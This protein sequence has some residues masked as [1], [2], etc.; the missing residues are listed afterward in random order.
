M[1]NVEQTAQRQK[2]LFESP[3][4]NHNATAVLFIFVNI[5]T[6]IGD[7]VDVSPLIKIE[8]VVIE[9]GGGN[10]RAYLISCL[11]RAHVDGETPWSLSIGEEGASEV[12]AD[13]SAA[14]ALEFAE[15]LWIGEEL[16][17]LGV[18]VVTDLGSLSDM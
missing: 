18:Y 5:L 9:T 6:V 17:K 11:V 4:E 10:V 15:A 1:C 7:R 13:Q 3:D 8:Y 12:L 2:L 14:L 16:A